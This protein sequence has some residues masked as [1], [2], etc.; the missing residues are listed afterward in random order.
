MTVVSLAG[1][2]ATRPRR[3]RPI[4]AAFLA[5]AIPFASAARRCFGPAVLLSGYLLFGTAGQTEGQE[6]P[7]EPS[8]LRA[9]VSD[10]A[11]Q[12]PAATLAEVAAAATELLPRHGLNFHF[13]WS[14]DEAGRKLTL[15]GANRVFVETLDDSVGP[16]ACGEFWFTVP[17]LRV[18][19]GWIDI[20]HRG[21]IVRVERPEILRLDWTKTLAADGATVLRT[22]EMPDWPDPVGIGAD[23]KTVLI[24]FP[25]DEDSMR[26]WQRI[27]AAHGNIERSRPA[28][29]IEIG[30]DA[31][32]FVADAAK[33]G[34]ETVEYIR[35]FPEKKANGYLQRLRF[36]DSGLIVEYQSPCT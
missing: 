27:R 7:L 9:A 16:D 33:Y 31:P 15:K 24:E 17:A 5:V 8:T 34:G 6:I 26:W 36:G 22:L 3:P 20:V 1:S 23:G 4:A 32:V 10:Y 29:R 14:E 12:H 21:E 30:G 18:G 2:V 25:L 35:D 28:L 19:D 11:R 13:F